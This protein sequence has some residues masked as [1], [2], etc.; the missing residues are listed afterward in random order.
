MGT[1]ITLIAQGRARINNKILN[2][3]DIILIRPGEA[4]EF[5]ALE[6][7]ITVVVKW[8][9]LLGDKYETT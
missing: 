6:D 1:E 8:P 5:E 7:T 2:Q 4:A 3:G 9:S